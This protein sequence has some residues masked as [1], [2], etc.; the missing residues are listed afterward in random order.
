MV[1][2]RPR[3]TRNCLQIALEAALGAEEWPRIGG[4]Q[5]R[6]GGDAQEV[7]VER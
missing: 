3:E 6:N 7:P 5:G 1:A 2:Y 4:V